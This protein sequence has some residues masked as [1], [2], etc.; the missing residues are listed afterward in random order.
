[1]NELSPQKGIVD[2]VAGTYERL[3]YVLS[4]GDAIYKAS[5][6]IEGMHKNH[7]RI[8]FEKE[9][10]FVSELLRFKKQDGRKNY[11]RFAKDFSKIIKKY[12]GE[13]ILSVRT[14]MPIVTEEYWDHFV[15][16]RYP[17]RE[18]LKKMYQSDEFQEANLYRMK[19]LERTITV[20]AEPTPLPEK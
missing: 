15:T 11:E 4:D 2:R 9:N 20:L 5:Y 3:L 18:A 17:S 6:S 12:G 8:K 16:F 1:M 14:E 19:S 10:V 13:V 7:T